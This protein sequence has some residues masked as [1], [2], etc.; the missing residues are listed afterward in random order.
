MT[1]DATQ[2]EETNVSLTHRLDLAHVSG[3]DLENLLPDIPETKRIAHT[4][5]E[6][7]GIEYIVRQEGIHAAQWREFERFTEFPIPLSRPKFL[8]IDSKSRVW[9]T[10]Y[11]DRIGVL[12]RAR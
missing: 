10:E 6:C 11:L 4:C 12:D 9:F 1:A 3:A 7:H 8:G 5:I 2:A